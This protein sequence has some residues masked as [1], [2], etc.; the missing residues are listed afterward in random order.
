MI[1]M[2]SIVLKVMRQLVACAPK[3][4]ESLSREVIT[5]WLQRWCQQ[6]N[7]PWWWWWWWWWWWSCKSRS[8]Y[9]VNL[10]FWYGLGSYFLI[11]FSHISNQIEKVSWKYSKF[12]N[13]WSTHIEDIPTCCSKDFG[14]FGTGT[15]R[16]LKYIWLFY[17]TQWMLDHNTAICAICTPNNFKLWTFC[18]KENFKADCRKGW[19][20][21]IRKYP[22]GPIHLSVM[23][24]IWIHSGGFPY[25]F[26]QTVPLMEGY[27]NI[28]ETMTT[29]T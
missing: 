1:V 4:A 27:M 26:T 17:V 23:E 22:P 19:C 6:M 8:S 29:I 7:V 15:L 10:R 16:F 12:G 25:L 9:W 3:L 13:T 24:V 2:I 5:R 28:K 18:N 14:N 11:Q 21:K 20:G